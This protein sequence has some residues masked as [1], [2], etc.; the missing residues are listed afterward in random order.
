VRG[1]RSTVGDPCNLVRVHPQGARH[2]GRDADSAGNP[3][4]VPGESGNSIDR[5]GA[6]P[7]MPR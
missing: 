1:M 2:S 7:A 3:R 6:N 5:K 4:I